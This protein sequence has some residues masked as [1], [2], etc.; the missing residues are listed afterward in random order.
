[1]IIANAIFFMKNVF[2]IVGIAFLLSNADNSF[3]Q[4]V[5]AHRGGASLSPENTLLAFQTAI[6]LGVEYFELDIRVSADDSIMVMHDKK[7]DRT[8][9]GNGN[10][11]DKTYSQLRQLDAGSWFD[12]SIQGEKIPNFREVLLLT[13]PSNTSII[14]ELKAISSTTIYRIIDLVKEYGMENRVIIAGFDF[15]KLVTVKQVDPNIEIM[16]FGTYSKE[17]IEALKSIGGEWFGTSSDINTND[18]DYAHIHDILI[19]KWTINTTSV[20]KKMIALGVDA[21]TTD[22]PQELRPLLDHTAPD[23]VF[24]HNAELSETTIS[25]IWDSAKEV[26]GS[27]KYYHIYKDT[28]A[29][30]STLYRTITD[31]SY[32]DHDNL[33]ETKYFYRVVAENEA[34]LVSGASNEINVFTGTDNT[35]PTVTSI[36]AMND[37]F[38]LV[39]NFSESINKESA[40]NIDNYSISD[41]VLITDAKLTNHSKTVILSTSILEP[42]NY[43]IDF[44][45]IHDTA[46]IPNLLDENQYKFEFVPLSDRTVMYLGFEEIAGDIL[47]D[48]AIEDANGTSYNNV[49]FVAGLVGN[50]LQF[51]GV[52]DYATIALAPSITDEVTLSAWVNLDF[53]PV[54]LPHKYGPIFDSETDNYILYEDR[55]NG[56]LRFKVTTVNGATRP[57][58]K[59]INIPIHEWIHIVGVYNSSSA[60]IY[61]NGV[62]HDTHTGISGSII[63]GQNI[64][65]GESLGS[66]FS[67]KI[68]MIQ[69]FDIALDAASIDRLYHFESDQILY[70]TVIKNAKLDFELN[71]NYPNPASNTTIINYYLPRAG[72]SRIE[73]YDLFGNRIRT[74]INKGQSA[75]WHVSSIDTK[76]MNSGEYVYELTYGDKSIA[77]KM[78]LIK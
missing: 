21:I 9:N 8:T 7:I 44:L 77:K 65:L 48:A 55:D 67:G 50:A 19:N 41:D 6:D 51:D 62:L 38:R 26:D 12:P 5:I 40:E 70:T 28:H 20:M 76:D 43:T 35:H 29:E 14:I 54:D 57:G 32:V 17:S 56:E 15:D 37:N 78:I 68:D 10:I 71:Q 72:N 53:T 73:I 18:I 69:V 49:K 59:S 63:Q 39:I 47:Y 4:D 36:F 13:A 61:L 1:M 24:L 66:Y 30:P 46:N 45:N 34:G 3:G 52:D 31:T 74:I 25:L 64:K 27:I 42:N 60:K 33:E 16:Q 23:P 58:I 11:A 75:G 22:Y 2:Y